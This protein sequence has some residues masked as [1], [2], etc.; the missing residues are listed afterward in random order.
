ME[1]QGKIK[2]FNALQSLET[3]SEKAKQSEL[4]EKYLSEAKK[5]YA[6]LCKMLNLN[7]RQCSLFS[8]ILRLNLANENAHIHSICEYTKCSPY[9]LLSFQPDFDFLKEK[10]YIA[11]ESNRRRS[12]RRNV[13]DIELRYSIDEEIVNNLI[14]NNINEMN[15]NKKLNA[16]DFLLEVYQIVEERNDDEGKYSE[17]LDRINKLK[18]KNKD[19]LPVKAARQFLLDNEE[20]VFAYLICYATIDCDEIGL[21]DLL[22]KVFDSENRKIRFKKNL[23]SEKSN[24]S[25]YEL[26]QFNQA[27]IRTDREMSMT[28]KGLENFIGDEKDIFFGDSL[29]SE[30]KDLLSPDTILHKQLFYNKKEGKQLEELSNLLKNDNYKNIKDRL[31]QHSMSPALTIL[32]HGYPGTGK[33]E[34]V[35]QIA[36]ET[37]RPLYMIDVSK[38]KTCWFGES[39]RNLKKL[40]DKYRKKVDKSDLEP[41]MLFNEADA[42][43]SKRKDVSSSNVAQTEN[44]IQNIILQ[45]METL[46]GIL[47]ATTNMIDNFDKAFERRF[48]YK[49]G[50]DKPGDEVALQIWKCRFPFVNENELKQIAAKY[51]FSGGQIENI[52]RK[53]TMNQVLKGIAPDYFQ[54][55]NYCKEEVLATDNQR[56]TLGFCIS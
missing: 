3:L 30:D 26:I 7:I 45:E 54:I 49:I 55:E 8:I 19:C 29:K 36:R 56:K 14:N 51:K 38:F 40:F 48:L 52:A 24:L 23:L 32:F 22:N 6:V 28:E 39:E 2:S 25:K 21:N 44:A 33:T 50:F 16:I 34:T 5:E 31:K 15:E 18:D 4:S 20:E 17:M 43:F 9:S 11:K 27:F 41:I 53:S 46:E 37:G 47:I 35:M 1:K 13:Y 10:G 42:I 12:K